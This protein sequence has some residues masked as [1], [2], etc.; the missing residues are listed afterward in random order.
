MNK[1][2]LAIL[3]SNLTGLQQQLK[4]TSKPR[5]ESPEGRPFRKE[6]E[7]FRF[8]E[9]EEDEGGHMD[10]FEVE[11]ES[12]DHSDYLALDSIEVD[13]SKDFFMNYHQR[14]S[15]VAE[16]KP[17]DL[18]AQLIDK[19]LLERDSFDGEYKMKFSDF[20]PLTF[21][22]VNNR[23]ESKAL[24]HDLSLSNF[25]IEDVQ[26][27]DILGKRK[28]EEQECNEEEAVDTTGLSLMSQVCIVQRNFREISSNL[29][30]KNAAIVKPLE[31]FSWFRNKKYLKYQEMN[32]MSLE[33][34]LAF[35][36]DRM[37]FEQTIKKNQ[38][39]D[40]AKYYSNYETPFYKRPVYL[41]GDEHADKPC[42][43][44]IPISEHYF[45]NMH[46]TLRDEQAPLLEKKRKDKRAFLHYL[47]KLDVRIV[48]N[49][50]A[51]SCSCCSRWSTR[52]D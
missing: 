11:Y 25:S 10:A 36:D 44:T 52:T 12:E 18:E 19:Q 21:F 3:E 32:E 46:L 20:L 39:A 42:F 33:E 30:K 29:L 7:E 13:G 28:A 17:V 38:L 41:S 26:I 1:S 2:K 40:V 5:K 35:E 16:G 31:Q 45:T 22:S 49:R 6:K 27:G 51:I 34:R 48:R 15:G 43:N 14:E 50:R 24:M 37:Q 9:L 4:K 47:E 23:L 8:V